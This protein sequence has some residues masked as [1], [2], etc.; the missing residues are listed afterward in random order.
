MKVETA[1]REV[2]DELRDRDDIQI[3]KIIYNFEMDLLS[4]IQSQFV[5]AE[6][7]TL[8]DRQ[9]CPNA[10]V[11]MG[12]CD[13]IPGPDPCGSHLADGS[14][15]LEIRYSKITDAREEVANS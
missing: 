8:F 15:C 2:H 6:Q 5:R 11:V 12:R 9:S 13:L 7:V 1:R 4:K 14:S 3:C 10:R